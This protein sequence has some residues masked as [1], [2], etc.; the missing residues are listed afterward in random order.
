MNIYHVSFDIQSR[1]AK[2]VKGPV[3]VHEWIEGEY[4]DIA[5]RLGD[6]LYK[7]KNYDTFNQH[8]YFQD[9]SLEEFDGYEQK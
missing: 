8:V 6:I 5:P 9:K 1:E 2:S 3:R 7:Y 4:A